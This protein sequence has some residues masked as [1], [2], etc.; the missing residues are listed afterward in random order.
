MAGNGGKRP[1]A[2]RKKGSIAEATRLKMEAKAYLAKR[3]EDEIIPLADALFAKAKDGEVSAIKEIFDR[4]W[5]KAAQP[6][7]GI[8][9]LNILPVSAFDDDQS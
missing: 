6:V 2:G 9:N 4:A 3:L 1:G 8:I 5:G 7:E